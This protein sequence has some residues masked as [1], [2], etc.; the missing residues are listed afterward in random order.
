MSNCWFCL[1]T[2][3]AYTN[4][5]TTGTDGFPG[6][7]GPRGLVGRPGGIGVPGLP[8]PEGLPGIKGDKGQPGLDGAEGP[9]GPPGLVGLRGPP[10]RAGLPGQKGVSIAVRMRRLYRPPVT[11][12]SPLVRNQV[13]GV[14]ISVFVNVRGKDVPACECVA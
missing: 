12:I 13:A 5:T 6:T 10:G 7:P 14:C 11:G 8:G 1:A 9:Q 2:C 4:F 3:P